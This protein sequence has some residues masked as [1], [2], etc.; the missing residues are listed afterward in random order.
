[1]SESPL[2][3]ATRDT[4]QA[5]VHTQ[6]T[7]GLDLNISHE[8]TYLLPYTALSNEFI[9]T[10][11]LVRAAQANIQPDGTQNQNDHLVKLRTSPHWNKW[12]SGHLASP[13]NDPAAQA[14]LQDRARSVEATEALL[15]REYPK[16]AKLFEAGVREGI[17]QEYIPAD[18][19]ARIH[20]AITK[21]ALQVVD[22]NAY[23]T[24]HTQGDYEYDRD[25]LTISGDL[26]QINLHYL[27]EAVI[28][29][30][31]HKISGG[32]FAN[33]AA[34]EPERTRMGFEDDARPGKYVGLTELIDQQVVLGILTGDFATID[35]DQ[36]Q[37][38]TKIYYAYRKLFAAHL[39]KAGGLIDLKPVT[40]S[41]FEDSDDTRFRLA[42]RRIMVRQ[43]RTAYGPDALSELDLLLREADTIIDPNNAIQRQRL[44]QLMNCIKGPVMSAD[45]SVLSHGY[46]DM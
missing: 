10:D 39:E 9:A 46:V 26:G 19:E 14:Y 4:W 7:V 40:R 8:Y 22:P 5:Q 28:H 29:E 24:E 45:G 42:D 41:S 36:R 6:N 34:G 12:A 30:L 27:T 15:R 32:R 31:K 25:I 21:T 43:F 18:V 37:G 16:I 35:P 3:F 23:E 44:Q 38:D 13:D 2:A 20:P 33:S 11:S 1:M 17:A